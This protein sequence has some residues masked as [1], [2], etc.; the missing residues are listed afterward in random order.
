[1]SRSESAAPRRGQADLGGHEH[2]C[3]QEGPR[4]SADFRSLGQGGQTMR[5]A[6]TI[7]GS[8]C[9]TLPRLASAQACVPSF[10]ETE[11]LDTRIEYPE[12]E[13]GGPS[14]TRPL[15]VVKPKLAPDP[16]IPLGP[17][18]SGGQPA[19]DALAVPLV[20]DPTFASGS[21]LLS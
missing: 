1:G 17:R 20:P 14:D 3:D 9:L 21:Y 13:A 15:V 10:V 11:A 6:T 19:L 7:L 8:L 4:G 2:P 12:L 5:M 16:R 18:S